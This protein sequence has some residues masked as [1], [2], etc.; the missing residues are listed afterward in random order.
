M[1]SAKDSLVMVHGYKY[2]GLYVL[3]AQIIAT[4]NCASMFYVFPYF[5]FF[6]HCLV[7]L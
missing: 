4:P 6:N 1:R 7:F 3:V 5:G 2:L